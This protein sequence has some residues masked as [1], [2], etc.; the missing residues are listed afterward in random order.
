MLLPLSSEQVPR[1]VQLP[2]I[3]ST[4]AELVRLAAT[5]DAVPFTTVVTDDQTAGRGRRGRSWTAPAGTSL[6]ISVL[7]RPVGPDGRV[8]DAARFG[9][10]SMA[11][12][13]AMTDAVAGIVP[14]ASVGF[15][16]PNDVLVGDRKICGVLGELLPS[17][18]GVVIGAG[19]NLTMSAE[20]LPVPTATSAIIEGA[21]LD[22]L[23]DRVLSAYLI[24]L[25]ALVERYGASGGDADASG[26]RAAAVERC[27]TLGRQVR[28]ELPGGAELAGQAVGIDALGR[29]EVRLGSGRVE[30]IAAGDVIHLR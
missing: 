21:V 28:A 5:G 22:G 26:L 27:T 13:V 16:W 14:A 4:N 23:Q 6:A 24:R 1:L 20:Q 25:M 12:G 17:G 8:L 10:L 19:V 9:W 29:L 11:A 7:V 3:A 30:A 15:K 2:S 18:D